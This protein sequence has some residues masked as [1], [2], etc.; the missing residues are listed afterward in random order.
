MLSA[1]AG[2]TACVKEL[3][4][5]GAKYEL[6]DKGGSTALHWAMDGGKQELIDWMVEDGADLSC[7]DF[8]GWTPLLRLG[9][10]WGPST[11]PVSDIIDCRPANCLIL[12]LN[13]TLYTDGRS[14]ELV[15]IKEYIYIYSFFFN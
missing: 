1:Y 11:G 7:T 14:V 4:H 9:E 2:Q 13:I 8:N 5:F 6:Q 3:R 12:L 10:G 15:S